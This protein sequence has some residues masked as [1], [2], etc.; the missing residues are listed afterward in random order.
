MLHAHIAENF[1]W[2]ATSDTHAA[3]VAAVP[4]LIMQRRMTP[5]DMTWF[6]LR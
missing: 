6:Q 1:T 5:H 4:G 3:D 2:L